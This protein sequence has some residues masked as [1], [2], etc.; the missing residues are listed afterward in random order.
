[1]SGRGADAPLSASTRKAAI[2]RHHRDR[3]KRRAIIFGAVDPDAFPRI[4]VL[5]S[6]LSAS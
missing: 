3:R 1:M 6:G 4:D 2:V 5:S